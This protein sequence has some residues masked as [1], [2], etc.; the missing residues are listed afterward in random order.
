[1]ADYR[2]VVK[3]TAP[4]PRPYVWEIYDGKKPLPV[5]RSPGSFSSAPGAKAAGERARERLEDAQAAPAKVIRG[6]KT[7]APKATPKRPRDANQLAKRIVDIATDD[8]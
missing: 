2:V 1:M 5:E 8:D 3:L 7:P 6:V 4:A